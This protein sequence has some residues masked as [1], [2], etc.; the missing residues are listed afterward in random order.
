MPVLNFKCK[1]CGKVFDSEVGSITYGMRLGF[2]KQPECPKCGRLG[3][4]ELELTEWGQTLVAGLYFED[5]EKQEGKKHFE[6]GGIDLSVSRERY[7]KDELSNYKV[8]PKCRTHLKKEYASYLVYVKGEED[9]L[10]MGNDDGLFCPKC[11]VVVLDKDAIA[12]GIFAVTRK[13]SVYFY[14]AGIVDT[15]AVPKDKEYVPLGE[16]DNPI[17]LVE[18]LNCSE[19]KTPENIEN[20]GRKRKLGRNEPCHCGS[21]KKYKRCC[22]DK[23]MEDRGSAMRV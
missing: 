19:K 6:E 18:F 9:A 17:P 15:D 5:M 7:F 13:R 22:L 20:S 8:C 21:G 12:E 1:K 10:M 11:P 16:D 2:E 3:L 14:V 23:D 4:E